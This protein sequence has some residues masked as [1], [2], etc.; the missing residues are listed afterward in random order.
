MSD[1]ETK[2]QVREFIFSKFPLARKK[3][4]KDNDS[5]LTS[6]IVDSM[7]VLEIVTF[8]ETDMS[9][10]LTDEEVL[11]DNFNSID[12]IAALIDSKASPQGN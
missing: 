5:L 3:E 1:A 9:L 6:G 12:T 10:E 4:L 11:A 7:G 2:T 8:L